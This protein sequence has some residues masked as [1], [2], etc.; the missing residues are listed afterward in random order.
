MWERL[1]EDKLIFDL[2]KMDSEKREKNKIDYK[3]VY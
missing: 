1:T 2:V 3:I